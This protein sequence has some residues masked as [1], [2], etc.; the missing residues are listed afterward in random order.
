VRL[1]RAIHLLLLP[2]WLLAFVWAVRTLESERHLSHAKTL[3]DAPS[4]HLAELEE[5]LRLNPHNGFALA[6]VGRVM[7][8]RENWPEV[9]DYTR[10]AL[11]S[12]FHPDLVRQLANAHL[13]LGAVR[14]DHRLTAYDQ[15]RRFLLYLPDDRDALYRLA[16]LCL[17]P[18]S[19]KVQE[20]EA[21]MT[22]CLRI[23]PPASDLWYTMNTIQAGQKR[24]R[25]AMHSVHRFL[26]LGPSDN[27]GE[28]VLERYNWSNHLLTWNRYI[29]N[30]EQGTMKPAAAKT[31]T[32]D[33]GR[34]PRP[35]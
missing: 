10:R 33:R 14:G 34:A 3:I 6:A 28:E 17:A 2:L 4:A 18:G 23:H 30:V 27:L 26:L 32:T 5:S 13:Q 19:N 31:L 7:T 15:Y 35:N 25:E 8:A 22:Y 20:A 12:V 16:N 1:T 29:R 24:S 21:L 11:A 9:I